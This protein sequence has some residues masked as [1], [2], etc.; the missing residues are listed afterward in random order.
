MLETKHAEDVARLEVIIFTE[1]LKSENP[2]VCTSIRLRSFVYAPERDVTAL[3]STLLSSTSPPTVATSAISTAIA[4]ASII[5]SLTAA[6]V[7]AS[8]ASTALAST[9]Q[10]GRRICDWHGHQ[11]QIRGPPRRL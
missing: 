8:L 5:P 7:V 9:P 4:A 10:P 2:T 11:L 6:A 1:V 3:F